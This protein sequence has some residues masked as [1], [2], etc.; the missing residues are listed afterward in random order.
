M[1][2][3]GKKVVA[4]VFR[5]DPALDQEPRFEV[6][7]VEVEGPIS[8]MILMRKIHERDS[9]FACRTSMCLKGVCGS[10]LVRVDGR[11]LLG[12][13][14]LVHPGDTV[15]L[16]PHSGYQHVRDLV[17]DFAQAA[18]TQPKGRNAPHD[19]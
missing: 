4:R 5:F 7:D 14:T 10:C 17:V 3:G 12:C 16:E 8:V 2:V 13:S 1:V 11:D 6:H 15:T 19:V 18:R 9:T